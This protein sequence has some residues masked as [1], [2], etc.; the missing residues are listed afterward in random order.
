[1]KYC[2]VL[3]LVALTA[4]SSGPELPVLGFVQ[5][6]TL[7]AQTGREFRSADS[8]H[9]RVWVAAIWSYRH[10]IWGSKSGDNSP[11]TCGQ[12]VLASSD[13]DGLT[14][15]AEMANDWDAD[16]FLSIHANSAAP[17]HLRILP[18]IC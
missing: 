15:R 11:E 1:M 12:L 6:F 13:D 8:L 7:T 4:C 9:G 17:P 3:F 5:P 2:A 14:W 18:I 16:L 10:S